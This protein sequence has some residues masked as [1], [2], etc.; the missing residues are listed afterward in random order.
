[1]DS[2]RYD[3]LR[4]KIEKKGFE[5]KNESLSKW[6]YYFS[7]FGNIGSIFFATFFLY[8]I[9][10]LAISMNLVDG[11]ASTFLSVLGSVA[12]LIVFEVLKRKTLTNLS[13][14]LIKSKFNVKKSIGNVLVSTLL[15]G[16]SFYFSLN[17][18]KEFVSTNDE[19]VEKIEYDYTKQIDS[20]TYLYGD[21]IKVFEVDNNELRLINNEIRKKIVET[22]LNYKT[23]R[24]SY[25][26]NIKNNDVIIERNNGEINELEVERDKKVSVIE[27]KSKLILEDNESE[28]SRNI[29]L[30]ILISTFIELII[31][32]GIFFKEYYEIFVYNLNKDR[33]EP[34]YQKRK[35]YEI[36][37][38]YIYSDGLLTI[39]DT[40]ISTTK[41]KEILSE[42]SKL[43]NS[44][45]FIKEFFEDMNRLD[46]FEVKGSRRYIKLPYDK[47]LEIVMNMDSSLQSLDR[48]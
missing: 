45:K 44:N 10:Y 38:K 9:L 46:V 1:M 25:E 18:A 7:F 26:T 37:L 11:N 39:G 22:P 15:I 34:M 14:D 30:F 4:G 19:F 41:L 13:F 12:I 27:D 2:K 48:L 17:G 5:G 31:I 47:A 43:T 21:R 16:M 3:E 35:K 20:I 33:L 36:V 24:A 6:L 40:I 28:D 32:G 42:R 29:L 23:V 8:P